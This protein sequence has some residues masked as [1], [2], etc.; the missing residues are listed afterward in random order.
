MTYHRVN[1]VLWDDDK[2]IELDD[3]TGKLWLMLLTGSQVTSLP[4]LQRGGAASLAE[5]LRRPIEAVTES[6]QKLCLLE[7]ISVDTRRRVICVPNAPKHNPAESPN[8][9]RAWWNRWNE[10]PDCDLKF[11]HIEHL[12]EHA[13]LDS[14]SHKSVWDQTFGSV[15]IVRSKPS[16][17]PRSALG[18]LSITPIEALAN[19]ASANASASATATA[20]AHDAGACDPSAPV[21]CTPPETQ[22]GRAVSPSKVPEDPPNAPLAPPTSVQPAETPPTPAEAT[23][24]PVPHDSVPVVRCPTVERPNAINGLDACTQLKA[25]SDGK[26]KTGATSQQ[27][28][29]FGEMVTSLSLQHQRQDLI[30][31]LGAY[32][33]AGG[34][35]WMTQRQ[36]TTA[37]LLEKDGA[38]LT[39]SVE[40]AL[41]WDARG[42]GAAR[43]RS[44]P[45]RVISARSRGYMPAASREEMEADVAERKKKGP[46]NYI[47]AARRPQA[48][49]ERRA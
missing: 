20:H 15:N 8:H 3:L 6:L 17:S 25:L 7:M 46:I 41:D 38:N 28:I 33:K 40:Q 11:R 36:P 27:A 37:W 47:E 44:A 49:M 9:L 23:P 48:A 19:S 30:E 12:K 16:A 4:G 10:I 34:F 32:A 42:R 1:P 39:D 35:D 13:G 5:A 45:A 24:G 2:F 14:P 21:Q 29:A 31:L 22:T 26:L 18:G 43:R